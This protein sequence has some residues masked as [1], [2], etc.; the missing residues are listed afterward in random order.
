LPP[1]SSD[2]SA[3][4]RSGVAHDPALMREILERHLQPPS[5]SRYR[6]RDCRIG[7]VRGRDGARGSVRYDL[8]VE[9]PASGR[10]WDQLVTGL[11]HG[12]GRT[13][14]LWQSLRDAA[15]LAGSIPGQPALPPFA[16]L[17]DLDMLLQVFPADH[18]LPGLAPL[19]AGPPE[20]VAAM[21]AGFGPGE[22]QLTGW[23][24][25]VVRY[26]PTIRATLRLSVRAGDDAT[27]QTA[28]RRAYAKVYGDAEKGRLGAR[29]QLALH[30]RVAAAGSPFDVAAPIAYAD[31]LRTLVQGEV[32]GTPLQSLLRQGGNPAPVVR[33]AAR[34]VAAF[35]RL[36]LAAPPRRARNEVPRPLRNARDSLRSVRPDLGAV[37]AELLA[38]V[39]AG[40]GDQPPGPTHGDLKPQHIL[41]AGERVALIDFD[42]LAAGDPLRDVANLVAQLAQLRDEALARTAVRVFLEEYA[43]HLPDAWR[44]RIPL[45]WIPPGDDADHTPTRTRDSSQ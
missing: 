44:A 1:G 42:D 45:D 21:L 32:G 5:G 28:E 26:R 11:T 27:G 14:R 9:D 13:R 7:P 17:P 41:L 37:V 23:E 40:L 12:S 16:Y 24:T 3:D 8:S 20:L 39:A 10:T 22:W 33:A 35:H 25:E 6:I 31:G 34:A 15:P 38:A 30:D 4:A 29:A 19:V 2:P 18:A 43:A 36:D